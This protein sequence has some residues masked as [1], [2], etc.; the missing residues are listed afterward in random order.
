MMTAGFNIKVNIWRGIEQPD[1][2][3]GGA[4]TYDKKR[5]ASIPAR[6]EAAKPILTI[7]DQGLEAIESFQLM[8]R[9]LDVRENDHVEV[10][11]PINHRF[12]KK[13][14]KIMGISDTSTNPMDSRSFAVY[15][16]RRID[17]AHSP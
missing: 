6:L 13:W 2:V 4:V 16:V 10:I 5:F 14:L 12:Y 3:I 7:M 17:Y 15:T 9:P 1:D 11:W 8:I